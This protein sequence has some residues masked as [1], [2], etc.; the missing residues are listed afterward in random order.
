MP[1]QHAERLTA[2]TWRPGDRADHHASATDH[3]QRRYL[4]DLLRR[5]FPVRRPVQ[6]DFAC[7]TGRAIRLL[8]GLVHAAHGYD[9]SDAMLDRARNAGVHANL[10]LVAPTGP[11]PRVPHDARPLIV[12]C[13]RFLATVEP[14]VRE[15]AIAFAAGAL[16]DPQSGL[17]VVEHERR[18]GRRRRGPGPAPMSVRDLRLLLAKYGFQVIERRGFGLL[19]P[20]WYRW[21]GLRQVAFA[22]DT[23]V[24]W[25][26]PLTDRCATAFYVAQRERHPA[27]VAQIG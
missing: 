21:P 19:T 15:L 14:Q 20:G 11:V 24:T 13:T 27:E 4:R 5:W 9:F 3:R 22:V 2:P 23:V 1:L 7:G 18:S 25:L 16:P 12:T 26:P 8:H 10:H 17:L 6:H